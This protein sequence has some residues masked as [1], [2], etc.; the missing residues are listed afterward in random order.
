LYNRSLVLSAARRKKK[1]KMEKKCYFC[2]DETPCPQCGMMYHPLE[3]DHCF[4]EDC[5]NYF[6][7]PLKHKVYVKPKE[8]ENK[9]CVFYQ[10]AQTALLGSSSVRKN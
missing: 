9:S 5:A 3:C 8:C 2:I 1:I 6:A 7:F 4:N 10:L